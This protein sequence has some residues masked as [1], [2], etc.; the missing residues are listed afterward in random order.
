MADVEE[1]RIELEKLTS[2]PITFAGQHV[3][4]DL[5]D[6][7][8]HPR[9]R[10][11][12]AVIRPTSTDEV[13]AILEWAKQRG[14]AVT[15][16][17]SGTGLSGGVVPVE[18]GIVLCFDQMRALVSLN[19]RDHVVTVQAGMTLRDLNDH[20]AGT[21]LHYPVYPGELSGSLGGNVN[22]NAGGMRAVRHG[23]TRQHV[24]GLTIV[25]IDGTIL[26][27]G[28]PVVKSSSG[29]DLTQLIVGSE[30]HARGRDR[31]DTSP[32]PRPRAQRDAARPLRR[33]GGGDAR[34][35]H[36]GRVGPRAV[37]PRVPSTP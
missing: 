36:P 22:T 24:L 37:D 15:P 1:L 33:L 16:R 30:G 6:E 2:G 25:L 20:L 32:L 14:L 31:S 19:T 8:L 23:V 12:F 27:T 26:H 13:A 17:G 28:G 4:E 29:Y 35:A 18:G 21:G 11:P 5:R 7:S 9:V 34:G 3:P 10:E